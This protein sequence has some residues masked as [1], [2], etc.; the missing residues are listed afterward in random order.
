MFL[1]LR[2]DDDDL[3]IEGI[4]SVLSAIQSR[5]VLTSLRIIAEEANAP[6]V[7]LTR[8]A[9]RATVLEENY[10]DRFKRPKRCLE[11]RARA[12]KEKFQRLFGE[13]TSVPASPTL[14]AFFPPG[15]SS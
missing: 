1:N 8:L 14:S 15:T 2:D 4:D 11:D 5:L 12:H 6:A 10:Q 3:I 9:A 13:P 7:M